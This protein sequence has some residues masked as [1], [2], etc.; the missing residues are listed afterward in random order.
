MATATDPGAPL[1]LA[2]RLTYASGVLAV[3]GVAFLVD[4]SVLAVLTK[5]F[6]VDPF[7][8]RLVAIAVATV[9]AWLMHR[10]FSFPVK[11]PPRFAE[12]TAFA[13]L[14]QARGQIHHGTKKI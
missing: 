1:R 6:H 13:T 2:G 8:A 12:F 9:A 5:A 4:A 10:T 3:L 14:D 11:S 7:L